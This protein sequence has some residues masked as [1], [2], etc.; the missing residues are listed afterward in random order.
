MA[1]S[2]G[3]SLLSKRGSTS[4]S[5]NIGTTTLSRAGSSGTLFPDMEATE[6][7][8]LAELEDHHWWYAERRYLLR[9]MVEARF[10]RSAHGRVALDI[11]AAAGGNT[12]VLRRL[13]MRAIPIEY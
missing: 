4:S 12:R 3:R 11:G 13:G 1:S 5:L 10:P 6:V 2:T 7:R 9:R 8:K